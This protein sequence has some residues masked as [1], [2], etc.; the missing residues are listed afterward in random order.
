MKLAQFYNF[1]S[2]LKQRFPHRIQRLQDFYFACFVPLGLIATLVVTGLL[3]QQGLEDSAHQSL[4]TASLILL[5]LVLWMLGVQRTTAYLL[6]HLSLLGLL[7]TFALEDQGLLSPSMLWLTMMVMQP[8]FIV[9]RPLNLLLLSLSVAGVLAMYG[10]QSSGWLLTA[11]PSERSTL[12][13]AMLA[14]LGI[15]AAQAFMAFVHD[16]YYIHQVRHIQR[17]NEELQQITTELQAT[18][19]HKDRFLAM[20]SH[21]IRTPLNGVMG[22]LS[23]IHSQEELNGETRQYVHQANTSAKHL[24]AVINDLLDLSQSRA[25]NLAI[26]PNVV[27]LPQTLQ[28]VFETLMPQAREAGL[29]YTLNI[30]G[31]LPQWVRTDGNRLAQILINLLGN[32]VKF[33]RK[34]HV[35]LFVKTSPIAGQD[36]KVLFQAEIDDTGIGIPPDLLNAIFDP[37]VQIKAQENDANYL[38]PHAGSGLGLTISRNLAQAMDGDI[39][40]SSVVGQGSTFVVRLAM[41][42]AQ[43]PKQASGNLDLQTP[44]SSQAVRLLVVDDN[45]VNRKVLITMLKRSFANAQIDEADGGLTAIDRLTHQ[46]YD[47]VIMDLVMPD[48]DGAEVVRRLRAHFPEPFRSVPVLGLTANP[49]ADALKACK[50]AGMNDVMGKPFDR[51]ELLRILQ[52]WLDSPNSEATPTPSSEST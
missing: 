6:Y 48:L 51:Q 28:W 31:E 45:P 37:F 34:G 18:N 7:F 38:K 42:I 25:G 23:L 8:Y 46:L 30:H 21:D 47:A 29:E 50:D 27:N 35:R 10:A 26:H 11:S 40:A 44:G 33:T 9:S 14:Y 36:N 4:F 52:K 16:L 49:A 12:L 19:T 20:V 17:R 41:G 43:A 39:V 32:A 24:L 22:Y 15:H 13:M 5:S 2:W 1:Y 3:Y